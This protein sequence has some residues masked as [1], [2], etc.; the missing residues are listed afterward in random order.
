MPHKP[1][2]PAPAQ[3]KEN[4]S[5]PATQHDVSLWGGELTRRIDGVESEVTGVKQELQK[6]GRILESIL[7]VLESIEG[8]LVGMADHSDKLE[9]HE[10]RLFAVERHLHFPK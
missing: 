7:K 1:K 5:E 9:R 3:E 10:Q 8:R 6:H 4:G 2:K